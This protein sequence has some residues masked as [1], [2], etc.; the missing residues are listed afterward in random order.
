MWKKEDPSTPT[1]PPQPKGDPMPHT[2]PTHDRAEGT[3]RATIG[4]SISIH[5][6]VTGDEDLLIQGR[7][8]GSVELRQQAITVGQDGRVTAAISGRIIIVEGQVEGDLKA[9][10]QIILKASA[11]VQGDI[12]SPR[13]V[14]ED[15]A[16]FSGGVDMGQPL[17]KKSG[18][19]TATAPNPKKP[20]EPIPSDSDSGKDGPKKQEA[21]S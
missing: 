2:N 1:S 16:V 20:S 9:E 11:K 5:G 19:A 14:L 10:E 7:V 18:T 21:G 15:G 8:E 3:E 4:R 17:N 6:E 13:V 12:T